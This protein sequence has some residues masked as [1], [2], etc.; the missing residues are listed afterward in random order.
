MAYILGFFAADGSMI[1]TKRGGHYVE[2]HSTDVG[3]LRLIR[4]ALSSDHKIS[5][6]VRRSTLHKHQY[7]LQIGS[8]RMFTDLSALGMTPHKSKILVFPEVPESLHAHFVRGYF[9]GDGCIYFRRLQFADRKRPRSVMLSLFTSGSR[10]FLVA[11]HMVLASHG[12]RGGV[13]KRKKRGFELVLSHRDSV[14]LYRFLYNNLADSVI[15]LPRK[16]KLFTRA[17]E[18][19]YGTMR[20]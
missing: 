3:L 2:F 9:D 20:S 19:L 17:V 1:R 15:F 4:A 11:L 18:T 12:V 7:R 5:R 6:R 8:M 16:Y 14:A 10:S 13:V